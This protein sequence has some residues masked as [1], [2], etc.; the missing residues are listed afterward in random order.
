[1]NFGNITNDDLLYFEYSSTYRRHPGSLDKTKRLGKLVAIK[2]DKLVVRVYSDDPFEE[3]E[4]HLIPKSGVISVYKDY[5]RSLHP[6]EGWKN[7]ELRP[8]V[9]ENELY[10]GRKKRSL[11]PKSKRKC[12]CK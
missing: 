1:M 10:L 8:S 4:V 2:G 9:I 5:A 6:M 7:R 11:K 12:R 3:G